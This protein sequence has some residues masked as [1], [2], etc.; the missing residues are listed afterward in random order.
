MNRPACALSPVLS[1][2]AVGVT[3]GLALRPAL[4]DSWT[5]LSGAG[6]PPDRLLAAAVALLSTATLAACWLW[7]LSSVVVCT[8]EAWSGRPTP[9]T[10]RQ[11]SLLRPRLVRLVV[12]AAV[13]S[14][15]VATPSHADPHPAPPVDLSGLSLPDRPFGTVHRS[16]SDEDGPAGDGRR[17]RVRKGDSLWGIAEQLLPASSSQREVDAGWRALYRV[18]RSVVGPDPSLIH[19]GTV[20]R[21]PRSVHLPDT[22]PGD[23]S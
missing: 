1:V 20:L 9:G 12:T 21:V 22:S 18:N 16:L 2:V 5:Q 8:L 23:R 15:V 14:V 17:H 10:A 19:P 6:T 13:G 4:T 11:E 3:A 7:L